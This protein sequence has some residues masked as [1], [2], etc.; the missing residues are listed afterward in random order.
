MSQN[1]VCR[2]SPPGASKQQLPAA[3][4]LQDAAPLVPQPLEIRL[5]TWGTSLVI[6]FAIAKAAKAVKVRAANI[7]GVEREIGATKSL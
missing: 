6:G 7:V 4:E 1:W 5:N 2:S 3:L